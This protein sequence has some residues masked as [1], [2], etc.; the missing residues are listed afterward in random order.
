MSDQLFR[1]QVIDARQGA[2]MA[3]GQPVANVSRAWDYFIA[4][5]VFFCICLLIFLIVVKAP[6]QATASGYLKYN[7]AEV[8]VYASGSGVV[9]KLYV[10]DGD[11]VS[12][13]APLVDIS[14][15][16]F[17]SSGGHINKEIIQNLEREISV[18][19]DQQEGLKSSTKTEIN[20]LSVREQGNVVSIERLNQQ[21]GRL[22]KQE[23]I[24]LER[25]KESKEYIESG[26]ITQDVLTRHQD[27][28]EQLYSN[29]M[30]LEST[31]HDLNV[32][33]D[34]TPYEKNRAEA[35][36]LEQSLQI[37]QQIIQLETQVKNIDIRAGQQLVAS[38]S[39]RVT[40][41]RVREGEA[42][43]Q[44][45]L[46]L[47]IVPQDSELYAEVFVPSSA[48]PFV[49]IGQEVRI[50]YA[51]LPADKFGKA[52][53]T[54][55]NI[56]STAVLSSELKALT[57]RESLL[58]RVEVKL[59]RQAIKTKSKEIVLLAGMELNADVVLD[60]RRLLEWIIPSRSSFD[61]ATL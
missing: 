57:E 55:S 33:N 56:A 61:L 28:V 34:R 38:K 17:L 2:A 58:Y 36:F 12:K 27:T 22:A 25:V 18:L 51:A 4:G 50:T 1:Q 52:I 46:M 29:R 10:Q 53:G 3:F 23:R 32:E 13:G 43:G 26:L 41:V 48:I 20:A 5:L 35:D 31:L 8:S 16:Q 21:L 40:A 6:R 9:E 42:V 54:I 30:Q 14:T 24:A 60:N 7:Q 47:V 19:R 49:E 44:S 37:K 39:G 59:E 45:D 15:E 11:F